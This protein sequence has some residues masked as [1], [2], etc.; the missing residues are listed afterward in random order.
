MEIFTLCSWNQHLEKE[1]LTLSNTYHL[2]FNP[3][4]DKYFLKEANTVGFI[5]LSD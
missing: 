4:V 1:M 3:H 5:S 2:Y